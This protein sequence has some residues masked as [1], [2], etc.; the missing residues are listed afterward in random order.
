V[1]FTWKFWNEALQ[2]SLRTFA[3]GALSVQTGNMFN[4]WHADWKQVLGVGLG[5]AW[6]SLLMS[7][8]RSG[9]S[10]PRFMPAVETA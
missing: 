10:E 2:R 1:L 6:Y 9:T 3:Q 7:V 4:I 5:A 8:D